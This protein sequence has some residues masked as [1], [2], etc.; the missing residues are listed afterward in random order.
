MK[1]TRF[2]KAR[3][4]GARAL[5]LSMGAPALIKIPKDV[6]LPID[7]AMLEFKEGVIPITVRRMKGKE[8]SR[9]RGQL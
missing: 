9:S 6:I 4:I 5:Q 1:Y 3:I 2:E 8:R 7:I